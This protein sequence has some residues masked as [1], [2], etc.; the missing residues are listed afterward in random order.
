MRDRAIGYLETIRV[1]LAQ[2]PKAFM[3][4]SGGGNI[5]NDDKQV[6][7]TDSTAPRAWVEAGALAL[8]VA[9]TDVQE[10]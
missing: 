1:G 4:L 2:A 10:D 7:L 8:R 9:N 6:V 5:G 3:Q